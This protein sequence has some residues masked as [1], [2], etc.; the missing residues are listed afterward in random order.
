[1]ARKEKEENSG[2]GGGSWL[3]TYT[4][5]CTL[6]LTFFVLLLS[7]SVIDPERKKEALNSLVGAF[8]FLS[9]GRSPLGQKTGMDV[10]EATAPLRENSPISYDMLKELTI[11]NNLDP[12]AEVIKEENR[13]VVRISDRILFEPGSLRLTPQGEKFLALLGIY[14]KK[15]F[16]EIEIRGHVDMYE[17][18]E[19]PEWPQQAWK[20]SALRA[21]EVYKFFLDMGISPER[22]SAHGLSYFWP[23]VDSSEYPHLRYKNRRVDIIIGRNPT[24]P[25]SLFRR[26]PSPHSYVNYKNF[27]FRLFPNIGEESG[28]KKE[29]ET[30]IE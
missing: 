17:M 29:K 8:G 3:T 25:Q 7:M 13:I 20:L 22:M 19:N 5:L 23:V 30:A 21:L 9:G 11:R 10:R 4:D 6:L 18:P 1:M 16:E 24:I 2:G 27:F 14:L 12:D 26:K 28:G 15:T